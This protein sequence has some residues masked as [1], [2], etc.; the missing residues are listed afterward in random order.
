MTSS[1]FTKQGE[2]LSD[3]LTDNTTDLSQIFVSNGDKSLSRLESALLGEVIASENFV[4]L[5]GKQRNQGRK[6]S[7]YFLNESRLTW[8]NID[9]SI[10]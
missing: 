10:L 9:V 7:K 5:I 8:N 4:L 3:K 2:K 1:Y 6:S